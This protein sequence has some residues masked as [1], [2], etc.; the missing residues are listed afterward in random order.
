[1][2]N[3]F[4]QQADNKFVNNVILSKYD[5]IE[6]Y[7][8]PIDHNLYEL[9][10]NINF[11]SCIFMASSM[12][13][14]MYQFIK[15]FSGNNLSIFLYHHHSDS[16][17]L[18][19]IEFSNL[20]HLTE[21]Y[22]A[23]NKSKNVTPLPALINKEIFYS[24]DIQKIESIACFLDSVNEIPSDLIQYLYPNTKLPIKMFNNANIKHHQNIGLLT[25]KDKSI[26]LNNYTYYI[27]I[28]NWYA[29]EAEAC[30]SIVLDTKEL[31][32]MR[33]IRYKHIKKTQTYSKYIENLLCRS[34]K[35]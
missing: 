14:E 35:T 33:A 22:L 23:T 13:P 3:L 18:L 20:R 17:G 7:S 29:A 8:A 32:N 11:N 19:D 2:M 27:S 24:R 10:Y 16:V 9:F 26:I 30:G 15:E 21:S 31:N 1:M 34:I 5:N 25:E 6:L 12:N 4:V 28:D